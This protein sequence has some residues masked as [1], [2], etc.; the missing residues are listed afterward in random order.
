M[1]TVLGALLLLSMVSL[2]INSMLVG[3]TTTMLEAEAQLNAV[4]I[5]QS[6]IDEIM[7]KSYDAATSSGEKIYKES[8]FTGAGSLGCSG[9]EASTVPTPDSYPYKSVTGYNDVD[10]Y[11]KYTRI[12]NTPRMGKFLVTDSVYYVVEKSPDIAAPIQ[13][14]HKKVVVTVRHPN[15]YA[16]LQLSDVAV[17]R[18]YF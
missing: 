4:S 13:T 9:A 17:Y 11:H 18:R 5:A 6:M 8:E 16:P 7:T 3:R 1:L 14:F 2:S 15:M 12:V 10:D